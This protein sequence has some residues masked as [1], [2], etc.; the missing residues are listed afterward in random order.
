MSVTRNMSTA[1]TDKAKAL[2]LKIR[3]EG[4]VARSQ[5]HGNVA[6]G[7]ARR[8]LIVLDVPTWSWVLTPA[9]VTAVD[10]E[11]AREFAESE[12]VCRAGQMLIW[13]GP[14]VVADLEPMP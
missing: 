13:T 1:L 12:V 7:L 11:A 8:G 10:E 5:A 6:N 2:L 9:G 4:P 14:C 3:D